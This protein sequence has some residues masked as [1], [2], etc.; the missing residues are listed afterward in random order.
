[1]P[2]SLAA[3]EE[4]HPPEFAKTPK[5][6]YKRLL[7]GQMLFCV[8]VYAEHFCSVGV[9]VL[10]SVSQEAVVDDVRILPFAC[11]IWRQDGV[12]IAPLSKPHP[13][14]TPQFI[15]PPFPTTV[16]ISLATT[17]LSIIG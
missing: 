10:E 8:N 15:A 9:L 14:S 11:V 4:G 3:Q 6:P 13:D 12:G 2:L 1:M 5:E 17:P 7:R 16:F